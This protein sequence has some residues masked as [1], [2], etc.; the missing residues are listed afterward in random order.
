MACEGEDCDRLATRVNKRFCQMHYY[1]WKRHGDPNIRKKNYGSGW[2]VNNGYIMIKGEDGKSR[3]EHI[4]IAEKALGKPLPP[5]AEVHHW[6]EFRS[7]NRN[8]N[9]LVCPSKSYH[10]LIHKRMKELG[11]GQDN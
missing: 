5:G 2:H 1:R 3:Y 9:L 4:L 11:Y 6:N 8:S 10:N 7:D